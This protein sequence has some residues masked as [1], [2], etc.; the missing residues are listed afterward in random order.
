LPLRISGFVASIAADQRTSVGPDCGGFRT[1]M[2]NYLEPLPR[3]E[4]RLFMTYSASDWAA[5]SA[6][7]VER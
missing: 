4:G 3:L 1:G 6:L 5:W 7:D 2:R